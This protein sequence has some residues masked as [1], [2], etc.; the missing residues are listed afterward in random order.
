MA[1]FH[2]IIP[3]RYGSQ[4]LPGKALRMLAGKPMLEHV[5]AAAQNAGASTVTI[6]TDDERILSAASAFGADAR[7]TSSDHLSGSDRI[8]EC[9][10]LLALADDAIV[11]NLQGDEP[12]TPPAVLDQVATLLAE[13][14]EAAMATIAS[15]IVSAEELH[16]PHAVKVVTDQSGRALYFSRAPIPYAREAFAENQNVLPAQ[17]T[18]LRHI[19]I[20]AYRVKFLQQLTQTKPSAAESAEQLEQLRA[21]DLGAVIAVKVIKQ[22]FPAGVDTA[23]DLAR[24]EAVMAR[25]GS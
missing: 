23:E 11:V 24:V 20:Y 19:G 13:R 21:M 22:A 15:P 17:P 12:L 18:Y 10:R 9:C 3:A 2:V 1:A 7:L 25:R 6:A 5:W 4:R 16:S 8:A 14:P